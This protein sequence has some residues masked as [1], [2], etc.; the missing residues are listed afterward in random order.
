MVSGLWL[1]G[2]ACTNRALM[3]RV[4]YAVLCFYNSK[5]GFVWFFLYLAGWLVYLILF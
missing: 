3:K 4:V 2:E 1:G 5:C